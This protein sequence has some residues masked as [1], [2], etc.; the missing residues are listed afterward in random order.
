[1]KDLNKRQ[2]LVHVES[3]MVQYCEGCFLHQHL[4][5]EGGR[6]AAHRFCIS[7][8]TVGEQLQVYGKKLS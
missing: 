4:K 3:L 1:M 8:C 2:L 6:R 7:K 5:K